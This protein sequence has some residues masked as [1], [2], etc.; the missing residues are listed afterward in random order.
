MELK[1]YIRIIRRWLWAIIFCTVLA[2][3]VAY[4]VSK[5]MAPVY[6]AST[7][8]FVPFPDDNAIPSNDALLAAA[9]LAK[10]YAEL[11]LKRPVLEAVSTNLKLGISPDLLTTKIKVTTI[12]NTQLLLITVEDT[13]PQKAADIANQVVKV[14]NQQLEEAHIPSTL[15]VFEPAQSEDKS[16]RPK[17]MQSTLLAS[18]LGAMLALGIAFLVETFD[19]SVESD[20]EV[21]EATGLT[22]LATIGRFRNSQR[23]DS[24]V[25]TADPQSPIAEIYRML[26]AKIQLSLMDKSTCTILVVSAGPNEGKS[27]TAANLAIAC[28]QAGKR[29]ILVDANLRQ[30]SLHT[31]LRQS[32]VGGVTRVLLHEGAKQIEDHLVHTDIDNLRL[33]PSGPQ[34][35]NPVK[36]LASQC[37][38]ELIEDLKAHAEVVLIDSPALLMFADATL[39]AQICDAGI[40]VVRA[41]ST[42]VD[43]L[44]SISDQL[45]R[46]RMLLLGVVL[47]QVSIS[48]VEN[49]YY[50]YRSKSERH[51]RL[52]RLRLPLLHRRSGVSSYMDA[53]KSDIIKH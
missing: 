46:S 27:T 6:Q 43:T 3:T 19:K 44:K 12:P 24:L 31:F 42:S 5:Q 52:L 30:P 33:M 49:S 32:N 38:T 17:V 53:T 11:M 15:S 37:M 41:G 2:G 9:N 13:N 48:S 51:K 26:W 7:T 23:N 45:E 50:S 1:Q 14:F 39:L 16:V 22:T 25:M 36:L 35:P 40:L 8:L 4:V 34:P 20:V 47:N 21:E 10:T 18:I 29:V 28:A